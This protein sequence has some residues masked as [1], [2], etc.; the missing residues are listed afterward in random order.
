[1]HLCLNPIDNALQSCRMHPGI[2]VT[3]EFK[4]SLAGKV[5]DSGDGELF[6]DDDR[7]AFRDFRKFGHPLD[8]NPEL[9]RPIIIDRDHALP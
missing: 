8:Q 6:H 4:T 1:M 7:W 2:V 5:P 9:L 3:T